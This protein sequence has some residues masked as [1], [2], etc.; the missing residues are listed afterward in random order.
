M[1]AL[2]LAIDRGPSP[3]SES[4]VTDTAPVTLDQSVA[5]ILSWVIGATRA[6]SS[7][8]FFNYAR[9]K[10]DKLWDRDVDELVW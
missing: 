10:S 4:A 3:T 2:G 1:V 6:K 8:K 7:G 5:G 9:V